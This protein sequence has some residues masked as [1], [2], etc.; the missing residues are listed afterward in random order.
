MLGLLNW[1]P[2]SKY[3]YKYKIL[4][5]SVPKYK[6]KYKYFF[7]WMP[8]YKYKYKYSLFWMPK[9]KYKYLKNVFKYNSNTNTIVFDS[10]LVS[11]VHLSTFHQ[12]SPKTREIPHS[13]PS[14]SCQVVPNLAFLP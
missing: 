2:L 5:F 1:Y 3:K 7:F 12:I 10:P 14:Q 11:R 4:F 9:Y 6:Y 13:V 8:K